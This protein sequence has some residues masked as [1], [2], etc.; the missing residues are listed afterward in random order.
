M[1]AGGTYPVVKSISIW[2]YRPDREDLMIKRT[3]EPLAIDIPESQ[4]IVSGE[5]IEQC[6]SLSSAYHLVQRKEALEHDL[7]CRQ[8]SV[9]PCSRAPL[10]AHHTVGIS[11][12]LCEYDRNLVDRAVVRIGSSDE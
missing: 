4:D 7:V 6:F 1:L 10:N 11:Q 12:P 5:N 2:Q 8:D 9:T 3:L